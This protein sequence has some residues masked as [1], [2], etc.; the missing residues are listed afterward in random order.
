MPQTVYDEVYDQDG[1]LLS[2]S[3]RIVPD[4]EPSIGEQIANLKRQ[5]STVSTTLDAVG[6]ASSFANAKLEIA[7]RITEKLTATDAEDA[8]VKG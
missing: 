3:E 2:R 7:S 1:T 8:P 4:P 6:R 5:L